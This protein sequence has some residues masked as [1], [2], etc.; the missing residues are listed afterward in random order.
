MRL[1]YN[2]VSRIT[3]DNIGVQIRQ[4]GFGNSSAVEWLDP[5]QM[6]PTSYFYYV[7]QALES[8]GFKRDVSI[9][10]AP[11]DFRKAPNEMGYFIDGLKRLVEETYE[12]NNKNRVV[13]IGHSM[14]N[15]YILY[16]LNKQSQKWKDKYVQ[17]FISLASPWG[18][19]V[20]P[21]RL[22]VS[23]DNLGVFVVNA[24]TV[25]PQQRSMP[26]TAWLMPYDTFW[27]ADEVLATGPMGNY[28]VNDY[29]KLFTD[30]D[31]MDGY[32]MRKDTEKLIYNLDAPGVEV[33]CLHGT[34]VQTPASFTWTA[35]QWP[36]QQP[37]T[38]YGPGDGT[39]NLRSLHG[40]LRWTKKQKQKIY[41]QEFNG[42]DHM[43][44]LDNPDV[45]SYIKR[46]VNS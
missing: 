31:Y 35:K 12:M 1:R 13:L 2:N 36:D 38:H 34:N 25:R 7:A 4:P 5:S 30:L 43:A 10:G 28:T 15:P 29:R 32:N 20:K 41:H 22:M 19:A 46:V 14:G 37:V 27:N 33:H 3:K 40:C 18:G 6:S 45:I 26:S 9:R 11:Y 21:I 39:V 16:M 17:S 42:S 24:L 44:I 23:G 8:W